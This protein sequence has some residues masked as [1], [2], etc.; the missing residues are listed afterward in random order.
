[1]ISIHVTAAK[2]SYRYMYVH[3]KDSNSRNILKRI[4]KKHREWRLKQFITVST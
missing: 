3:H 1:M 4:I 2:S